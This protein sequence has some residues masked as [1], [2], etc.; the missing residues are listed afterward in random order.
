[1][2]RGSILFP[3][4]LLFWFWNEMTHLEA[5]EKPLG[6]E[7]TGRIEIAWYENESISNQ[8]L[9]FMLSNFRAQS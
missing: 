3:P 7:E 6:F 9:L 1:M 4:C 8:H 2:G 5:S